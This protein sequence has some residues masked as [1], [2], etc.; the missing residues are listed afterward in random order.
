MEVLEDDDQRA[1]GREVLEQPARC[2]E[3]LLDRELLLGQADGGR[4]G[5]RHR[6]VLG[7]A[8]QLLAGDLGRVVL[9]DG[10]RLA[11]DLEERPEGDAAP[12][13]QAAAA[14]DLRLVGHRG[15]EGGEQRG[16]PYARLPEHGDHPRPALGARDLQLRAEVLQLGLPS[17][18]RPLVPAPVRLGGAHR[19]EPV[20][21]HSLGLALQRKRLHRNDLDGVLDEPVGELADQ[22]V[23]RRSSLLEPRGD[24]HGIPGHEPLPADRLARHDLARVDPDPV[25]EGDPPAPRE[26]GAQVHQRALHLGRRSHGP[27][28]VVLVHLAQAEDGHDR[29]ADVFLD[30]P[31][32]RLQDSAHPLEVARHEL[33][34][35]LRVER[36]AEV[37]GALQVAEDDRDRLTGLL[38]DRG[39][40][41]QR[42]PAIAAEA[43]LIR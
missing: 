22:D 42:G 11:D 9:Q 34:K 14:Y 8:E 30:G 27:E 29:V 4:E 32:V 25:L 10:R 24:V 16:L 37:G 2:P 38:E 7:E 17:H 1:A 3:R 43:K 6:L 40:G 35:G 23:V 13:R 12:V 36:L 20:R 5:L 33:A 19:Q 39:A 31:A 28:R 41:L 21:G 26:L 18:H 15:L